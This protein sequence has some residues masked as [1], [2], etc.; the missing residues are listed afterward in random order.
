MNDYILLPGFSL[1]VVR[2]ALASV[3]VVDGVWDSGT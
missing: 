3:P 1:S 2:F